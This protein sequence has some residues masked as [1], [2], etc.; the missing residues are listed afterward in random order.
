MSQ[1]R[2]DGLAQ[3]DTDILYRVMCIDMQV[4]IGDDLEIHHP[5]MGYLIQHVVEKG[6]PGAEVGAAA[7]VQVQAD[8]DLCL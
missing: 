5:M 1:A 6:Y 4:A 2:G 3:R 7:A 8:A